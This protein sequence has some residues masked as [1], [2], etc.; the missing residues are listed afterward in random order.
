MTLYERRVKEVVGKNAIII[1][2]VWMSKEKG[3]MYISSEIETDELNYY[4]IDIEFEYSQIND[5]IDALTT[6]KKD[7][8]NGKEKDLEEKKKTRLE[9]RMI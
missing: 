8:D 7:M 3:N 6:I 9:W 1:N 5:L 2:G 4:D